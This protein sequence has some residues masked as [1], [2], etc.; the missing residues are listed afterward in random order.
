MFKE[1]LLQLLCQRIFRVSVSLY[2]LQKQNR[3][4]KQKCPEKRP[5]HW[6]FEP[7]QREGLTI[8]SQKK[9]LV[10]IL[11][12]LSLPICVEHPPLPP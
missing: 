9:G 3:E 6:S 5:F 1:P 7:R 4:V 12:P 2:V 11:G 10:S 8:F